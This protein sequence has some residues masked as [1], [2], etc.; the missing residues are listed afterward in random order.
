VD[1][2]TDLKNDNPNIEHKLSDKMYSNMNSMFLNPLTPVEMYKIIKQLKNKKSHGFDHC[3]DFLIRQCAEN[4][5]YVLSFIVNQSFEQGIF[6]E[7]LKTAV[8][9]PLFK[10]GCKKDINNYR[11]INLLSVFS[12]IF[13]RSFLFRLLSFLN[14]S[15]IQY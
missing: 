7:I 4:L 13:E 1:C 9:K 2:I 14:D 12:K 5:N 8:I 6:P 10:K 15:N 11:P 3:S